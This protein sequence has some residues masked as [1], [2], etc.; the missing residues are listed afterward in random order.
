MRAITGM[1]AWYLW[2]LPQTQGGRQLEFGK[3]VR[4]WGKV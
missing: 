2:H 3:K 4:P 1:G